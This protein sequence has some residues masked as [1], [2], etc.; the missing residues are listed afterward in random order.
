MTGRRRL[1]RWAWV[2][3]AFGGG[4]LVAVI[5]GV[6]WLAYSFNGGW[7]LPQT[8]PHDPR[9]EAAH[10]RWAPAWDERHASMLAELEAAGLQVLAVNGTDTCREG[11]TNWKR[12]DPYGLECRLTWQVILGAPAGDPASTVATVHEMAQARGEASAGTS[13]GST[14]LSNLDH[15]EEDSRQVSSVTYTGSMRVDGDSRSTR[16]EAY[17][18]REVKDD[19]TAD[20]VIYT[21][22]DA[23]RSRTGPTAPELVSIERDWVGEPARIQDAPWLVRLTDQVSYFAR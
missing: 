4:A 15:V 17:A 7:P 3:L 16:L 18:R 9:V 23:V 8:D 20:E 10:E 5:L 19:Y 6:S 12:R 22:G 21:W 14:F 1:P 11:E 13:H 2:L